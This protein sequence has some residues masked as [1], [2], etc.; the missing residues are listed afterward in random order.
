MEEEA[1]N[2]AAV[3]DW[4]VIVG[5]D[6]LTQWDVLVFVYRH[7]TSL[8]GAEFI[9]RL[10]GYGTAPVVATLDVLE[11]MGLV[12]RS[13]TSQGV[14]LYQFAVLA[15]PPL[16]D[17]VE[18]LTALADNRTGRLYLFKKL[19]PRDRTLREG[20]QASKRFLEEAQ[21]SFQEAQRSFQAAQ[22]RFQH[23]ARPHSPDIRE[24]KRGQLWRKAV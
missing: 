13:R 9:A 12:K 17:A 3:D 20:L 6:S 10:L 22:Q 2:L 18:G 21:R 7:R 8:V 16:R 15:D 1:P 4:L 23:G 19:R 11:S 5:I 24:K 14:R